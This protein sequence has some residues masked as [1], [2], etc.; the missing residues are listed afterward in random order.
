MCLY[1]TY[2]KNK[3][4]EPNKKNGGEPPPLKDYRLAYV[5]R[6]CGRCKQC[7]KQLARNWQIRLTEEVKQNNIGHFVTLT[8]N[9][10]SWNEL[11][12]ELDAT[13]YDLD[14]GIAK[15]AIRRFLER[16]RKKHKKSIKHWLITELGHNGT[17]RIHLHGIIWTN[18]NAEEIRK[19]WQYGWVWAGYNNRQTYL[20][21][22]TVNYIIKYVHK[23]DPDHKNYTPKVLCSSGIGANYLNRA[24]AKLNQYQGEKTKEVY[25]YE[26]GHVASLPKYYKNKIYTDDEKE[27]LWINKLNQNVEYIDKYKIDK[28]KISNKDYINGLNQARYR[29]E[30]L[31]Y[32]KPEDKAEKENEEKRRNEIHEKQKNIPNHTPFG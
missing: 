18:Q 9:Q 28:T 4:Y 26:S 3:R 20:S 11:A 14:N 6:P 17:E 23:L 32:G 19:H 7:R 2:I 12:N 25:K 21:A 16:W 30:Q 15:L 5:P 29:S 1:T 22:R 27:Q 31:G 13:G 24:N 8:F 10:E